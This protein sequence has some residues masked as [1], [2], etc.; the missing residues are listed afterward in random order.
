[1]RSDRSNTSKYWLIAVLLFLS[2]CQLGSNSALE[3][4]PIQVMPTPTQVPTPEGLL[5]SDDFSTTLGGWERV[6]DEYSI[7]DYLNGKWRILVI[8]EDQVIWNFSPDTYINIRIEV[9]VLKQAGP[10]D[11]VMGVICGYQDEINFYAMLISPNGFYAILKIID[12]ELIETE[13]SGSSNAIFGGNAPNHI[14]AEC[15]GEWLRLTVNDQ[16]LI[17][18]QDEQIISGNIGLIA[19]TFDTPGMDVLFDNLEIYR[20]VPP[21][22][23]AEPTTPTDE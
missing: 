23:T 6:R 18:Y 12:D 3:D 8:Q 20:E 5:F 2:G 10:Q 17:E 4:Q 16:L 1:M 13:T 19:G 15:V 22:P 7:N 11:G 9:D 21:T 14:R